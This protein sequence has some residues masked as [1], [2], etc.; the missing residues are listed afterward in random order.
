[1]APT[2]KAIA[3]GYGPGNCIIEGQE[4]DTFDATP[5]NSEECALNTRGIYYRGYI[6]RKHNLRVRQVTLTAEYEDYK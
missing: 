2:G 4:V 6:G 3:F 1:M 5:F